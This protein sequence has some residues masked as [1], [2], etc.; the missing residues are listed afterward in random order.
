MVEC[1]F[2]LSTSH[3]KKNEGDWKNVRRRE[4]KAECLKR[5]RPMRWLS[6]YFI[7]SMIILIIKWSIIFC[8]ASASVHRRSWKKNIKKIRETRLLFCVQPHGDWRVLSLY[9]YHWGWRWTMMG[10]WNRSSFFWM[11]FMFTPAGQR[12]NSH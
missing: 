9:S 2:I 12:T 6:F 4:N 5:W 10:V 1:C 11:F 7:L 8:M 3:R